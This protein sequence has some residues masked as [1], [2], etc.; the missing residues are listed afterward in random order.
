MELFGSTRWR[1]ATRHCYICSCSQVLPGSVRGVK[2][3]KENGLQLSRCFLSGCRMHQT[4]VD[5]EGDKQMFESHTRPL[6]CVSI[7]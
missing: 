4:F 1:W 3:L 7:L 5:R 6:G 2:T